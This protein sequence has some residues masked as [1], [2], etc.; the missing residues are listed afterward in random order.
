MNRILQRAYHFLQ[1][2]I[3]GL[4]YIPQNIR[5][6]GIRLAAI[7]YID[8]LIPPGKSAQYISAVEQYVDRFT[9]E[10]V[11]QYSQGNYTPEQGMV[12]SF[13]KV[14]VWCC[15]WQGED[16]MPEI[17]AMC[18]KRLRDA[19]PEYAEIHLLTEKNYSDYIS[20]PDHILER[21]SKGQ[22]SITALS[23]ILR[24][25]LL[26]RYGGFWIDST[27]FVSGEFPEEFLMWNYYSQKMFDPV[28]WCHE[29]C[30]GRWCGFMMAGSRNNIIFR[31]I[32]DAYYLWWKK[33]DCVIDYVILDYF[34]LSAYKKI[35]VIKEMI[36]RVPDNNTDVFEMYRVLHLPYTDELYQ[37]L[38]EK[39]A[40]HKLT[41][42][43]D[44]I[45]TT[46]DGEE[47]L[48]GHLLKEVYG[49]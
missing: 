20:L 32:R 41:Y 36:D 48:Y 46:D 31:Y 35:P 26:A 1:R 17:V 47:T 7:I 13:D 4:K 33:H 39:T 14:P 43:I 22:M 18:H 44:L 6:Y 42:K 40:M 24:V 49:H 25:T 45:K 12:S 19:L 28:K 5:N 8:S 38:T 2:I 34:L 30:K 10:L 3:R 27:V 29:A 37:K 23:D 11:E 9:E 21:V 16:S 15:W